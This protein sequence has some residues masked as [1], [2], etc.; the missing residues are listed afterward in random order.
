MTD[1]EFADVVLAAALDQLVESGTLERSMADSICSDIKAAD[2]P[3]GEDIA[4]L[5]RRIVPD[6][7]PAAN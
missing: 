7:R 6:D 2:E 5:I 4:K 1:S 3:S